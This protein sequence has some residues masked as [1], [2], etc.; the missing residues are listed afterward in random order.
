MMGPDQLGQLVDRHAAALALY[1]RQWCATPED[2]VQEAFLKLVT[3]HLGPRNVVPWL[4]RVVR[5]GAVSASRSEK[6]RRRYETAAAAESASC[7]EDADGA[8]LALAL[9]LLLSPP[10]EIRTVHVVVPG[11]SPR[12]IPE[13]KPQENPFTNTEP[14]PALT[15]D[16][17]LPDLAYYRLQQQIM[18]FGVDGIPA[19]SHP[20]PPIYDPPVTVDRLGKMSPSSAGLNFF[21]Q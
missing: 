8:S 12:E 1:A 2:V 6:R 14:V 10:A 3:Q 16:N 4:Y 13:S 20:G 9:I 21:G 18:R 17:T 15:P 5:N 11:P 19:L 7:V